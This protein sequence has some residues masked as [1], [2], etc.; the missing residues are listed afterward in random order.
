M[1]LFRL[2]KAIAS[3]AA[4]CM[5]ILTTPVVFAAN[6]PYVL[7]F[8]GSEDYQGIEVSPSLYSSVDIDENAGCLVVR[9]NFAKKVSVS[10]PVDSSKLNDKL[11]AKVRYRFIGEFCNDAEIKLNIGGNS[12]VIDTLYD[13]QYDKWYE[14]VA[15]IDV[16]AKTDK[17]EFLPFDT[18][19][20]YWSTTQAV[21]IDYIG[22]FNT[23]EEANSFSEPDD[24]DE[25][26]IYTP[27]DAMETI[28][29]N[30]EA[31]FLNGY[32]NARS[33]K[34]DASITRAEAAAMISRIIS[35]SAA[36][37]ENISF[38]DVKEDEW[39][40]KDVMNLAA[41]KIISADTEFR[42]GDVV[43]RGEFTSMLY[44][45]GLFD[46]MKTSGFSDVSDGEY[47]YKPIITAAGNGVVNGY[48]DGNFR[49]YNP[50]TRA[51]A[52]VMLNRITERDETVTVS[53]EKVYDDVA[54]DYW[55]YK[56]IMLASNMVDSDNSQDD[57][58]GTSVALLNGIFDQY[59]AKGD[60][61]EAVPFVTKEML[62]KGQKGGEGGQVQVSMNIDSTGNFLLTHADVGNFL[63]SLDGGKT[64]EDTGRGLGGY[65]ANSSAIDPN[66]SSR[67]ITLTAMGNNAARSEKYKITKFGIYL[68]EDYAEHYTQVMVYSDPTIAGNRSCLIFDPTSFDEGIN[69]S[70]TAYYSPYTAKISDDYQSVKDF[71]I[72]NG[73]NEG[74]GLYR[75]D[76][77]GKTWKMINS[78]MAGAT[79]AVSYDDGTL[80]AVK[81]NKLYISNDKG[82]SFKQA[83]IN[84]PY[85]VDC[86]ASNPKGAYVI[87]ND[88]VYS[89]KNNGASFEKT[90][91]TKPPCNEG[92]I[93]C[94]RVS[95]ADNDRMAFGRAKQGFGSEMYEIVYSHDGGNT[96][97]ESV[98]DENSNIFEQEPRAK[99]IVWHPTDPD[100]LWT[101]ADWVESSTDG[102]AHIA[103]DF[104]GGVGTCLNAWWRPNIYNSDIW[105][106]PAQDFSGVITFD[107]GKT[108]KDIRDYQGNEMFSHLYGGYAVDENTMIVASTPTWEASSLDILVTHN[109]GNTWENIG[110]TGTDFRNCRIFQSPS[111]PN[112]IF[113]ADWRS[114]DG[115][116][117]WEKMSD[118]F[119]VSAYSKKSPA[120]YGFGSD[121]LSVKKSVDNGT[122]WTNAV[123]AKEIEGWEWAGLQYGL[124][125]DYDNDIL[126]YA[127][128]GEVYKVTSDGK[129]ESLKEAMM[130]GGGEFWC[131]GFAVDP[132]HPEVIYAAGNTSTAS[133]FTEFN[134]LYIVLRSCDSGKTWQVISSVDT[135]KTIV[136]NGP[137]V[138]RGG[139]RYLF[140]H[141]DTGYLYFCAANNGLYKLPPPYEIVE[142]K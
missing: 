2:K 22:F 120:I 48:S 104:N 110:K 52:V 74:V 60:I 61:W 129:T 37:A 59:N 99:Q 56:D 134:D 31:K 53:T 75:S 138:G 93:A 130:E 118:V 122:T 30:K 142:N 119:C 137:A 105:L 41:R 34:P 47:F 101:T 32:A 102:G 50:I 140:V 13:K 9:P 67:V 23:I 112:V 21:Y 133:Y 92:W 95:P 96:W 108:F 83:S 51:E 135:D 46:T 77:G 76:D 7:G 20:K 14:A 94:F 33:F 91:S 49:P 106:V 139:K 123:V 97:H 126:Y 16:S 72:E 69:G 8:N 124:D 4:V 5:F 98:Y 114:T 86:V 141:P 121:W 12:S 90:G 42:P 25:A 45:M 80:Y 100:K 136:K 63:R 18:T 55:A 70:K 24:T 68:S 57:G 128:Y 79:L 71:E 116:Y 62:D 17:I 54:E 117:T 29:V 44:R 84:S 109:G 39:Y 125:Y 127:Q 6:D 87:T 85:F 132:I 66:N 28:T 15:G 38:N 65:G 88:G 27:V 131:T 73:Y 10:I 113:A 40:Y 103:W 81:E 1:N 35:G 111:D 82:E 89:T 3:I 115:G 36:S 11:Y 58:N 107:G 43:T 64:W 19:E 78:D 26:P